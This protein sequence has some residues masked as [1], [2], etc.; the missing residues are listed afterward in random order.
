MSA[1]GVHGN[2]LGVDEL[3]ELGLSLATKSSGDMNTRTKA[4]GKASGP[5]LGGYSPG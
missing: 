1:A 5:R 4:L 2:I 3:A